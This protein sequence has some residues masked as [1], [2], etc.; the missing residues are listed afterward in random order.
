MEE[1]LQISGCSEEWCCLSKGSYNQITAGSIDRMFK[2]KKKPTPCD[3]LRNRKL[4]GNINNNE[5][6]QTEIKSWRE[7]RALGKTL[8]ECPMYVK[9]TSALT[10]FSVVIHYQNRHKWDSYISLHPR[11]IGNSFF[12][13]PSGNGSVEND[14]MWITTAAQPKVVY[15]DLFWHGII[16]WGR[17]F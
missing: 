11:D 15:C 3:Y 9:Q 17:F 5:A 16:S 14:G 1:S 6:K 7:K 8:K 10:R 12:V 2:K 4:W 13:S